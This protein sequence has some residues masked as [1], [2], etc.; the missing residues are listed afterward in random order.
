MVAMV[1]MVACGRVG[2]DERSASVPPD[3]ATTDT[4]CDPWSAPR[5][6]VAL[7]T[8]AQDWDPA[9]SPDGRMLVF[10]SDRLGPGRKLFL[11]TRPSLTADFDAPRQ[12][13][14][15]DGGT[16]SIEYG[17]T[18]SADGKRL[19]FARS[20]TTFEHLAASFDSGNNAFDTPAVADLPEGDSWAFTIDD[21]EAFFTLNPMP[22]DYDLGHA[23]RDGSGEW[24]RS[25]LLDGFNR[26]GPSGAAEGW[27]SFDDIHQTLYIEADLDGVSV[28]ATTKRTMRGAGFE[29]ALTPVLELGDGASDPDISRDTT[30][31]V[32]GSTRPGGAGAN[33]LYVSVRSC[34]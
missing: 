4:T 34:R 1:A 28:I 8:A 11:A 16:T 12:L 17:A 24:V 15:L 31:I 22:D 3:T 13:D 6:Q 5:R 30:T 20:D 32:F 21:R 23:A 14:E 33:D 25:P 10:G 29:P 26:T 19:F 27:P 7:A 2:F 18:W 9:L